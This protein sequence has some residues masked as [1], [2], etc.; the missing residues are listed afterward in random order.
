MSNIREYP[1]K[2]FRAAQPIR[3]V[4]TGIINAYFIYRLSNSQRY[5]QPLQFTSL[6]LLKLT[7]QFGC[8]DD[9][10]RV[11]GL[12]GLRTTDGVLESIVS[13]Y[14]RST[15][16]V[17]LEVTR[18]ILDSSTSFSLISS[19]QRRFD[20]EYNRVIDISVLRKSR[21]RDLIPS[22]VPQWQYFQTQSIVPQEPHPSFNASK[23]RH[24]LRRG[25]NNSSKI[26]LRGIGV[27]IVKKSSYLG[28]IWRCST[29]RDASA[30][31]NSSISCLD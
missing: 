2:S 14:S 1:R 20:S 6:Q 26:I 7:W 22:W 21:T 24:L 9:R 10:D 15:S 28:P 23:G 11:F 4:P 27:D 30:A 19:I 17:Y 5:S 25:C 31:L 3:K 12:L 8:K 16:R 29:S 13:D 18:K